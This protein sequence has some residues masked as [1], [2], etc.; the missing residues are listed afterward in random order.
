MVV[1]SEVYGLFRVDRLPSTDKNL[2]FLDREWTGIRCDRKC[3]ILRTKREDMAFFPKILSLSS[4]SWIFPY[5]HGIGNFSLIL[6]YYK[7]RARERSLT[8]ISPGLIMNLYPER[9]P[10]LKG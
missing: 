9:R 3:M 8:R 6:G 1:G 5:R 2:I 7:F 10:K 4:L